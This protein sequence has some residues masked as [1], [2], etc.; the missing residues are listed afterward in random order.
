MLDENFTRLM[1]W[2]GFKK[3]DELIGI[4]VFFATDQYKYYHNFLN[5]QWQNRCNNSKAKR[6]PGQ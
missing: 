6:Q 2:K 1:I 4:L 3:Q 5:E